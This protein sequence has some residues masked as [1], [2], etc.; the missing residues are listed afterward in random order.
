MQKQMSRK[1]DYESGKQ[2]WVHCW[3]TRHEQRQIKEKT[4][5]I[6]ITVKEKIE[7][8]LEVLLGDLELEL[9]KKYC[10]HVYNIKHQYEQ[11]K[12]LKEKITETECIVH[13]DF[14][15]NYGCKLNSEVQGMH[16]GASRNQV[17]LHTGVTYLKDKTPSSFCTISDNTRHD[18]SAIWAHLHP[19]LSEIK[20]THPNI[21]TIHFIS[22]GPTTQYRSRNNFYLMRWKCLDKYGFSSVTWNFT[23][24]GHGKGAPDGVGG[25][26][27]RTAD[28]RVA[29][30]SD[31]SDGK[32]L[33]KSL[34][35]SGIAVKLIYV[36]T[37]QISEIDTEMKNVVTSPVKGTM[38]IHQVV[39][40]NQYEDMYVR[41]LSCF[42]RTP[43]MCDC[44][45]LR[46]V[47]LVKH[48]RNATN[49][50]A[51]TVPSSITD[52][53]AEPV[54]RVNKTVEDTMS[55]VEFG[56]DLVGQWL[57]VEYDDL[58][59][60]GIVQDVDHESV[61]VKVMH[62]IGKNR[63][64]WP[65]RDDVLQYEYSQVITKFEGME[66]V[67]NR[68]M[69]MLVHIWDSVCKKMNL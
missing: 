61:T 41:D 34:S 29:Y 45:S 51:I 27:K 30:G 58:P 1:N 69:Q 32:E 54:N 9:K 22:D 2:T 4:Q 6:Q 63:Y 53:S 65:A 64:F 15:E 5:N 31:I 35:E 48:S 62:N 33:F 28:K 43:D 20:A 26:V 21:K 16:F 66:N 23:E 42:C 67:T 24:A 14:S 57:V 17:S 7:C 40:K 39:C 36:P 3:K 18:P 55:V 37:E 59:Y 47:V 56:V 19:I 12:T 11:I 10:R 44:L 49:H 60:P 68:H 8:T 38:S 13:V 25:L 50:G 52:V 46:S